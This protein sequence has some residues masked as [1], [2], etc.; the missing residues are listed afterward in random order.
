MTLAG[1]CGGGEHVGRSCTGQPINKCIVSYNELRHL[2]RLQ[3][4]NLTKLT[5]QKTNRNVGV[6]PEVLD[7]G[8]QQNENTGWESREGSNVKSHQ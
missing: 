7:I 8:E 5:V 3:T 1:V 4:K 6:Q 2:S